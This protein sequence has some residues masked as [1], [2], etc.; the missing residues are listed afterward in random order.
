MRKF[1]DYSFFGTAINNGHLFLG[2]NNREVMDQVSKGYRMPKPAAGHVSDPV[3]HIMLRCWDT[4]PERR[5][6]F[7]FLQH[8]FEDF[9]VSSEIP[10]REVKN[11]NS[12]HS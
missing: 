11:K 7:E 10:Y 12:N 4:D 5:P 6:T 8:F 2:M 1:D 9:P 3:Y